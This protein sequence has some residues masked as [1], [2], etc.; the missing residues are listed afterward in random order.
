MTIK[1]N[2]FVAEVTTPVV[3]VVVVAPVVVVVVV[4]VLAVETLEVALMVVVVF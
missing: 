3:V 4:R 1:E 2:L